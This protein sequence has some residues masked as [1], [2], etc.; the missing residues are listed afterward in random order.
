MAAMPVASL[1]YQHTY[2]GWLSHNRKVHAAHVGNTPG[3]LSPTGQT[4]E[5]C[6]IQQ[7]V[8]FIRSLIQVQEEFCRKA[9]AKKI[10]H[11]YSSFTK[12][13][14]RTLLSI[15]RKCNQKYEN[16]GRKV[17]QVGKGKHKVRVVVCVCSEAQSC[18]TFADPG[19]QLARLPCV[20][21]QAKI[22]DWI[23]VS[24]SRGYS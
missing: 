15:K 7:D 5:C 14:K 8:S 9:K 17:S 4:G 10:K 1:V 6:W 20:I 23:A 21:F 11:H 22:L 24:Y 12:N 16:Y 3:K 18:Q 2:T 19:L 13:F